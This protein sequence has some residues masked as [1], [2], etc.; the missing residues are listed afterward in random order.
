MLRQIDLNRVTALEEPGKGRMKEVTLIISSFRCRGMAVELDPK[1]IH[2]NAISPGL[3]PSEMTD[4]IVQS[5]GSNKAMLAVPDHRC[6]G[7]QSPCNMRARLAI[8]CVT[9]RKQLF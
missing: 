3:F 9:S 5:A 6:A 8:V 7:F 2:V 4:G 1:G